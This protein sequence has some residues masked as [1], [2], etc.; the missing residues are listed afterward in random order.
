ELDALMRGGG[1]E[2]RT[3]G[4]A[5]CASAF[6]C[7]CCARRPAPPSPPQGRCGRRA[8]RTRRPTRGRCGCRTRACRHRSPR[9]PSPSPTRRWS[10]PG[11]CT[12]TRPA[13]SATRSPWTTSTAPTTAPTTRASPPDDRLR[14]PDDARRGGAGF[15]R[16]PQDRVPLGRCGAADE[17][18]DPG[19]APPL[20]QARGGGAAAGRR[21]GRRGR[22]AGTGV[23][24]VS[25]PRP[26]RLVPVEHFADVAWLYGIRES[27]ATLEL[28]GRLIR[29]S[30][31]R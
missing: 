25:A 11:T 6:G 14:G 19:W 10:G 27:Q 4:G 22:R 3:P 7:P 21:P 2:V 15:P 31:G 20:L 30:V 5:R 12:P 13:P 24:V 28:T 18:V 8:S 17:R 29:V 16:Q 26:A 9:S 1:L 23:G